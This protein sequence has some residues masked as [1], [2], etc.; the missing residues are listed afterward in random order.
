MGDSN[1]DQVLQQLGAQQQEDTATGAGMSAAQAMFRSDAS[2]VD[3]A[4]ERIRSGDPA[5]ERLLKS[6]GAAGT[7]RSQEALRQIFGEL[8]DQKL[9]GHAFISLSLSPAP[10]PETEQFFRGYLDHER[11]GQ[12][13]GYA[14]GSVARERREAGQTQQA[15]AIVAELGAR[16][17]AATSD[18]GKVY[19]MRALAN[20]VH[21][22]AIA[23]VQ[24]YLDSTDPL[25]RSSAITAVALSGGPAAPALL[26]RIISADRVPRVRRQALKYIDSYGDAREV[27]SAVVTVANGHEDQNVRY[28][29][30]KALEG[31]S[32]SHPE[33]KPEL[34]R[35]AHN[36]P[37]ETIRKL[38]SN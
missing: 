37:T 12:Q 20:A 38:V 36:E 8:S 32:K 23:Y 34:D 4:L 22:D 1:F 31:W 16:L 35:I 30:V 2:T 18:S 11:Y 26:A 6:L 29:A 25:M 33:L 15:A 21:P 13:A 28:D 9:K 5:T 7:P 14:L 19:T 3:R 17:N 27:V 24:G 10:T